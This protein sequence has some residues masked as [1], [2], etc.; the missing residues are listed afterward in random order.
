MIGRGRGG[1]WR[2]AGP[3]EKALAD[4]QAEAAK[5]PSAENKAVTDAA[6][7]KLNALEVHELAAKGEAE[8]VID[9]LLELDAFVAAK[10]R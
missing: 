10:A 2:R 1:Y 5:L 8:R 4:A 9:L 6:Q 3:L 7:A